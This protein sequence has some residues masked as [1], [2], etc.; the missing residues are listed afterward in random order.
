MAD[1]DAQDYYETLQ[2]SASAD[3]ETIQRVYRLL[4]QRYHPDNTDTGDA[5]RFRLTTDAYRVLSDPERR[6]QYDAVYPR[7]RQE[8]WRLLA[9]GA[10]AENDV[11][12]EQLLRLTVLE[13]LYTQR[14]LEPQSPGI[15]LLDFEK[16]TGHPREHLEF[17]IWY[18]SQ[19]QFIKSADH[20]R[21]IITA[22]GVD[23]VEDNY[24]ASIRHRLSARTEA[25]A[26]M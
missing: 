6:A 17:T 10:P 14:R 12:T 8:R 21:L 7:H 3:P 15:F 4:A 24:R 13:V 20:S 16:L 19:K 1:N 26:D 5:A 22:D 11:E 25:H 9:I 2:V 23:H 18:L